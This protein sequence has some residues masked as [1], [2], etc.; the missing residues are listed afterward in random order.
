[1]AAVGPAHFKERGGEAAEGADLGGLHQLAEDIPAGP[2]DLLEP[3]QGL[4]ALVREA[5]A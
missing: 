4:S 5:P 2:G 1:M 3:S